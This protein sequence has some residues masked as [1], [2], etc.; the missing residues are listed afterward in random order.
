MED[1]ANGE[2]VEVYALVVKDG[3]GARVYARVWTV[4]E[5]G[6]GRVRR[7]EREGER[8]SEMDTGEGEGLLCR[9]VFTSSSSREIWTERVDGDSG[10]ALCVVVLREDDVRVVERRRWERARALARASLS[11]EVVK[12]SVSK[13]R[14][15]K[16][17]A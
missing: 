17:E 2:V 10:I 15:W 16:L 1:D 12:S 14:L 6:K 9:M 4:S 5:G 7:V 3:D 13:R 11:S 8:E